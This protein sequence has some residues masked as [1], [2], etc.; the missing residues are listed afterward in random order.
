M[1][2]DRLIFEMEGLVSRCGED[3]CKTAVSIAASPFLKT[4]RE[5]YKKRLQSSSEQEEQFCD[6]EM[7][8]L[9]KNNSCK[10]DSIGSH[11]W[12]CADCGQHTRNEFQCSCGRNV[13]FDCISCCCSGT[14]TWI[15]FEEKY[16]IPD[17]IDNRSDYGT[18]EMSDIDENVDDDG[19]QDEESDHEASETDNCDVDDRTE[20]PRGTKRKG[21]SS[22]ESNFS[23]NGLPM[24]RPFTFAL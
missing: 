6:A 17:F 10:V 21:Y 7:W 2:S 13:C 16:L 23:G 22:M 18:E 19:A 1:N 5:C 11:I 9:I 12:C 15:G 24:K 4:A 20:S 3:A 14:K 8:T